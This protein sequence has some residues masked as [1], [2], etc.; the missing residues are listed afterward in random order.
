MSKL[1]TELKYTKTHEWAQ[2]DDEDCILVGITDHAQK[3]LGDIVYIELP[4]VGIQ[5]HG[6]EEFGVVESVKAASDLY[7]PLSGEVIET[8]Q[9]LSANPALIN[10]D[11]YHQGWM[12]KIKPDDIQEWEDLMD[13][14]EYAEKTETEGK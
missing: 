12:I 1:P 3:L 10:S 4:E 6:G 5:L 7:A 2:R 9:A 8:N 11:A 13:A 14:D